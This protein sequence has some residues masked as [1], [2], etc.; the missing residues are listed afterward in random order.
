MPGV[1]GSNGHS[2]SSEPSTTLLLL[3]FKHGG[4]CLS[5][6]RH[7]HAH[8]PAEICQGS[9]E[10]DLQLLWDHRRLSLCSAII[11]GSSA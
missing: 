8:D 11:A 2:S 7:H 6:K 4:L 9:H 10:V 5:A 3:P 1:L